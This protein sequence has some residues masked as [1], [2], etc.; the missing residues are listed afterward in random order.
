MNKNIKFSSERLFFSGITF[1]DAE[2]LVRWR[3]N[4]ELIRYFCN[5]QPLTIEKHLIWFERYMQDPNRYDFIVS[6]KQSGQNIGVLSVCDLQSDKGAEI[7][8]MI[9]SS[10]HQRQGFAKEAILESMMFA[11]EK[12]GIRKFCA[13]IHEKNVPSIKTVLSLGFVLQKQTK[14]EFQHYI[15]EMK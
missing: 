12:W 9:A 2:T 5:P 7:G 13:E 6:C 4:D 8:Y 14:G 10:N 1:A 15:Y 11:K 3:S